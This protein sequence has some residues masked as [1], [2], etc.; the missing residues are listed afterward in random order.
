MET[1]DFLPKEQRIR[2]GL[3]G[4]G[5]TGRAVA[6]TLLHDKTIDLVW[7]IRK[8]HSL[9]NRSVPEFLGIESDED[10]SLL[11]PTISCQ[12]T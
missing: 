11:A 4:F 12:Q 3:V 6:A 2:V 8:T 7:V 5:K 1:I 10:G 9:E